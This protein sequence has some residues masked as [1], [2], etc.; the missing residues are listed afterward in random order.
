MHSLGTTASR[1]ETRLARIADR[2]AVVVFGVGVLV[3]VGWIFGVVA[4]QR[5]LPGQASMKFNTAL[6]FVLAGTALWLRSQRELRIGLSLLVAVLGALSLGESLTE[7]NFGI[8]QLV[9]RDLATVASTSPPGRMSQA[10]AFCFVLSGMA[11]GLIGVGRAAAKRVAEALALS[12]GVVGS[13]ALMGYLLGAQGLYRVPG[14]FS[15]ALHTAAAFVVL[16]AGLLCATRDGALAL[17]LRSWSNYRVLWLG[18]GVPTFLLAVIGFVSAA[19]L[20]SIEENLDILVGIARSR[21]AAA[22]E[23]KASGRDEE[24]QPV[25]VAAVEARVAIAQREAQNSRSLPLILLAFGVILALVTGSAVVWTVANRETV[26]LESEERHTLV[27]N[28]VNDGLWDWNLLTHEDY[29]SPRWK[30]ILGYANDELPNVESSF[31]D[32][33]HPDDKA[34]VNEALR[35]HLEEHQPYSVEF[36]LRS[37]DGGYCGVLARGKA[38]FDASGRPIRMLGS[39]TD[40][41]ERQRAAAALRESEERFRI[42]FEQAAIGVAQVDSLTGRLLRV[43]SKYCEMMGYAPDELLQFDFMRLTLPDDLG[44]NLAAIEQLRSGALREFTLEKRLI[45]KDGTPFWVNLSVSAMWPP[46]SPPSQH[47]A[48]IDDIQERKLAEAERRSLHETLERSVAERTKQLRDTLDE[49]T[50]AKDAAEAGSRAKSAFLA[51]MSHEIRTPLNAVIGFTELVLGTPLRADQRDYLALVQSSGE[52]LLNVIND[53]LDFSKI[54]ADRLDLELIPFDHTEL[55]DN[56]MKSFNLRCL[57]KNLKCSCRIDHDVPVVLT[58]DAGRLRQ[59]LTNLVGNAIKFT[60]HGEVA[61][62]VTIESSMDHTVALRYS[63]R[64]TGI[65]IS[66]DKVERVFQPFEQADLSTSRRFGG[67]GLGLAISSRLVEMMGG[68]I[69]VESQEGHGSTFHFTAQFGV[70]HEPSSATRPNEESTISEPG[71][72]GT[73]AKSNLPAMR[74]LKIL[75]AEDSL[76]NQKLT[77][78]LMTKYGH[79]LN[80]ANNGCEAFAMWQQADYDLI[81]MDVQM[82]EMDGLEATR[83][84]RAREQQSGRHIPIIAVTAHSLKGDRERCL[85]SGMDDYAAKPIRIDELLA[86]IQRVLGVAS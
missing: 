54:E 4:L 8:D 56:A 68:R 59:V 13:F 82:P 9:V 35:Q 58:G 41:T 85:E 19:R 52:S 72:D 11:L 16:A 71:Q 26:L 24:L 46:G 42:M 18:F 14:F 84:I 6:G 49:L 70:P 83:L 36:R 29:L 50:R 34:T 44:P 40:I 3:V 33:I 73:V 79:H 66:T 61:V 51:N 86:A 30:E 64:D 55:L 31:F 65:G 43:N 7:R 15:V 23:I 67:T 60:E 81:L 69:W 78:S 76:M 12:I 5:V 74:P 22:P 39:I 32:L 37:K 53:V 47:I 28:A 20:Q 75:L 21:D 45:R 2:C 62:V 25:A 27:E 1:L 80:I 57:Q 17:L 77:I 48:V 10:T 38:V 63:V